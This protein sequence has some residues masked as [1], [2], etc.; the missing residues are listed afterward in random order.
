SLSISAKKSKSNAKTKDNRNDTDGGEFEDDDSHLSF[1]KIVMEDNF[2]KSKKIKK[3][4]LK[5]KIFVDTDESTTSP[6]ESQSNNNEVTFPSELL[7]SIDDGKSFFGALLIPGDRTKKN[8]FA[9]KLV[10][11]LCIHKEAVRYKF[12]LTTQQLEV[13]WPNIHEGIL[14]KRRNWKKVPTN[15]TTCD[16]RISSEEANG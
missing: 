10:D 9:L 8:L 16:S 2:G 1:E 3:A 13:E 5:N 7:Y 4:L 12:K 6:S 14:N 11:K 15:I